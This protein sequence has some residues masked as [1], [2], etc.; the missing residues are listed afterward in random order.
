MGRRGRWHETF[1]KFNLDVIYMPGM[2]NEVADAMWR[3]VYLACI[4]WQ[5]VSRDGSAQD[6]IDHGAMMAGPTRDEAACVHTVQVYP[7]VWA[8]HLSLPLRGVV[9]FVGTKGLTC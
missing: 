1:S 8:Y 5:D 2:D 3:W 7:S 6:E 4:A 9:A